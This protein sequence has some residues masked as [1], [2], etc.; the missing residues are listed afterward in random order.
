MPASSQ[1]LRHRF[2]HHGTVTWKAHRWLHVELAD[3][4]GRMSSFAGERVGRLP[5]LEYLLSCGQYINICRRVSQPSI[6][7]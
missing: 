4:F 3:Q 1:Q 2:R 6:I 7:Y 5:V